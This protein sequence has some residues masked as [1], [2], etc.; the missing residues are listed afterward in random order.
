M[1]DSRIYYFG[2][3]QVKI[4]KDSEV[5]LK[6]IGTRIDATEIVRLNSNFSHKISLTCSAKSSSYAH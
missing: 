6:L 5:R 4:Q 3:L 2:S 1:L